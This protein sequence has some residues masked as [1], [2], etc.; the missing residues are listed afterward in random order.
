MTKSGAE[1]AV[2]AHEQVQIELRG[3]AGAIVVRGFEN[4]ARFL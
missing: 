2:R 1:L 3:H 4:V